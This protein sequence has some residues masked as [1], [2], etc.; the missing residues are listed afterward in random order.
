MVCINCLSAFYKT[1]GL[2]FAL[3]SI[4]NDAVC[5]NDDLFAAVTCEE[6]ELLTRKKFMQRALLAFHQ[7]HETKRVPG[8]KKGPV[9]RTD[10][11]NMRDVAR[12]QTFLKTA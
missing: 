12:V 4:R 9:S 5:C 7:Y 3:Q 8:T 10:Q 11:T 2:A 1:N 6:E